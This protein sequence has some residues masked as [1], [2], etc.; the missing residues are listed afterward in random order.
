MFFAKDE[1]EDKMVRVVNE[2]LAEGWMLTEVKFKKPPETWAFEF[3][4]TREQD[5]DIPDSRR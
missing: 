4:F 5:N 1:L 3:T 2:M